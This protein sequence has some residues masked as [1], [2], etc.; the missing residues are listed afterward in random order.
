MRHY[1]FSGAIPP[2]SHSMLHAPTVAVLIAPAGRPLRPAARRPG[3]AVQ[4]INLPAVT[5]AA[6]QH[7]YPAPGTPE[8]PGRCSGCTAVALRREVDGSRNGRNMPLH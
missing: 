7:L 6:D 4:A 1:F 2:G 5:S 8:E 3:A